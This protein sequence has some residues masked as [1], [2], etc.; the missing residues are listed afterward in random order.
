[1][2]NPIVLAAL[3]VA[4][5]AC[6]GGGGGGGSPDFG[7]YEL[8]SLSEDCEGVAGLNGQAIL[9]AANAPYTAELG[10]ITAG[11][12]RVDLT[13]L[14][15]DLTWPANPAA[16]CYPEWTES[17]NPTPPRVAI[18]GVDMEFVTADGKFDESLDAKGW[19]YVLNNAV[20][21]PIAIAVTT[22]GSLDGSWE[23]FPDYEPA[24]KNM[25]FQT[26]LTGSSA[27][28]TT[29]LV[30]GGMPDRDEFNAAIFSSFFAMATF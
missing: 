5:A 9:T 20:Q 21:T 4:S 3:V 10:Y 7:Q 14:D 22:R 18:E 2:R 27:T 23:P 29:G 25:S 26:M 15:I 13:A 12:T 6:S 19:L 24:S 11:G 28:I 17:T 1:M 30:G 16:T 8:A